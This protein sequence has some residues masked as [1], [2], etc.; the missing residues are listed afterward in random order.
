MFLLS[1]IK[2]LLILWIQAKAFTSY[3]NEK[4]SFLH[5]ILTAW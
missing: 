5:F 1:I 3:D 4:I 2:A